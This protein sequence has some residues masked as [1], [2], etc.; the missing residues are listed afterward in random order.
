[1]LMFFIF[2]IIYSI[3]NTG[4]SVHLCFQCDRYLHRMS[5]KFGIQSFQGEELPTK[6]YRG[7]IIYCSSCQTGNQ[8]HQNSNDAGGG[9]ISNQNGIRR[10]G[11]KGNGL[12]KMYKTDGPVQTTETFESESG[13]RTNKVN[14]QLYLCER[15]YDM[16]LFPPLTKRYQ[17]TEEHEN[18]QF[19]SLLKK[20]LMMEYSKQAQKL[21][22]KQE[23]TLCQFDTELD[24]LRRSVEY[25]YYYDAS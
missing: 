9:S 19:R 10:D 25:K 14:K 23:Q 15:C 12:Q 21:K 16:D 20:R 1:M 13:F 18:S 5:T 17:F 22:N 6:D 8:S 3:H 11:T 4:H 2:V 24:R 7:K